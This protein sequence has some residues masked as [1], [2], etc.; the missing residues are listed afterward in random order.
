MRVLKCII[1]FNSQ[2]NLFKATKFVNLCSSRGKVRKFLITTKKYENILSQVSDKIF[3]FHLSHKGAA[4]FFSLSGKVLENASKNINSSFF[5]FSSLRY[6][7][8]LSHP[9]IF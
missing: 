5:S 1:H 8:S 4:R 3:V 7:F 9:Q 6:F 2:K